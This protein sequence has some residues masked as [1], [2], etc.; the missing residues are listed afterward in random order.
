MPSQS[1]TIQTA[2]RT[3]AAATLLGLGVFTGCT[4]EYAGQSL[5]SPYYHHDDIQYFPPGPE[6]KLS[7]EAAAMEEQRAAIE[8]R[9]QY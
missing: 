7:R 2:R 8:S 5:P 3:L 4:A 6:M 1:S 9:P